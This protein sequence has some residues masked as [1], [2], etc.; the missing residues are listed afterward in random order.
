M[1]LDASKEEAIYTGKLVRRY[2]FSMPHSF[3]T[4]KKRA[5]ADSA[6]KNGDRV[7]VFCCGT[8]LDFP[9]IQKIIGHQGRIIGVDFS[10]KM[11][12]KGFFFKSY[13]Y[14]IGTKKEER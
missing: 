9:H 6:M 10:S 12:K 2:D 1:G 13:Y 11:L 5:F 7:L 8:G 4:W 3:S 14:C